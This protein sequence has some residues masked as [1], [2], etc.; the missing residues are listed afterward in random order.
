MDLHGLWN[1]SAFCLA[2]GSRVP[3][4]G[5]E[6]TPSAL[7]AQSCIPWNT[8]KHVSLPAE[9]GRLLVACCFSF[10]ELQEQVTTKWAGGLKGGL[11]QQKH[12]LS[13]FWRLEIQ[14]Q[15]ASETCGDGSFLAS[16][17]FLRFTGRPWPAGASLQ[18]L[19]VVTW[20]LPFCLCPHVALSSS[21]EDTSHVETGS[22]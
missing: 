18:A 7:E 19:L 16:P 9:Y 11:K 4:P 21:N 20:H 22:I 5:I 1:L 6:P 10:L 12:V 17:S 15:G 8:R 3:Q 13:E 14:T 2:C